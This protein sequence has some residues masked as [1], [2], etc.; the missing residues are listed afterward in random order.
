M[1][2]PKSCQPSR[3]VAGR[4]CCDRRF[5]LA[6]TR[7]GVV[8]V[9]AGDTKN[10]KAR[11]PPVNDTLTM[12]LKS[13]KLHAAEGE[14]SCAFDRVNRIADFT[15]RTRVRCVRQAFKAFRSTTDAM[16]SPGGLVMAGADLAP[17]NALL[18]HRGMTMM[19]RDAHLPVDQQAGSHVGTRESPSHFRSISECLPEQRRTSCRNVRHGPLAQLAEQRTLNPRKGDSANVTQEPNPLFL[20]CFPSVQRFILRCANMWGCIRLIDT[21]IDT[22]FCSWIFCFSPFHGWICLDATA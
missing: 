1:S 7:R 10:R 9:R 15:S 8:P 12:S 6:S 18:G 2:Y 3:P 14:Q 13:G 20:S 4:L 11:N 17:V 21:S 16:G 19:A 22:N 5:G